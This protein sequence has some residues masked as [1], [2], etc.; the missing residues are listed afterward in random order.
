[1]GRVCT[2]RID[3]SGFWPRNRFLRR[4]PTF[5]SAQDSTHKVLDTHNM[6]CHKYLRCKYVVRGLAQPIVQLG[7]FKL[8]NRTD[9]RL[10]N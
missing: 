8:G 6:L 2:V 4:M 5:F 3:R 10:N 1:M 7:Q 9:H